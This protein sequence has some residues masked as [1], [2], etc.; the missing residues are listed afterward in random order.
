MPVSMI[1]DAPDSGRQNLDRPGHRVKGGRV[2]AHPARIGAMCE[3]SSKCWYLLTGDPTLRGSAETPKLEA[4]AIT[5]RIVCLANSRKL[6]GRC[7]AGREFATGRPG[8]W[9]R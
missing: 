7:V 4:M 6:Q 1:G 3:S 2:A 5:K 8:P 9:V